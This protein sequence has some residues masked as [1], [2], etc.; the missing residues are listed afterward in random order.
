M[1]NAKIMAKPVKVTAKELRESGV[2]C[3][4]DAVEGLADH[5]VCFVDPAFLKEADK[6][7]EQL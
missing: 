4:S 5:C 1:S 6:E 3:L 2:E 7:D